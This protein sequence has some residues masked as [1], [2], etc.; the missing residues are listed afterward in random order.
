M[1]AE[2]VN[3]NETRFALK[4][5]VILCFIAMWIYDSETTRLVLF[6]TYTLT[7]V[8]IMMINV[9]E[10]DN[11][12]SIDPEQVAT[13]TCRT[14]SKEQMK[15]MKYSSFEEC[16]DKT[17]LNIYQVITD[18]S[19]FILM[20]NLTI[21]GL[22]YAHWQNSQFSQSEGGLWPDDPRPLAA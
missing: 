9:M 11:I 14:M 4:L 12:T 10:N 20:V 22:L 19:P 7:C 21:S 16:V 8:L 3:I 18:A 6:C 13:L 17:K 2:A 5:L 15:E 1:I